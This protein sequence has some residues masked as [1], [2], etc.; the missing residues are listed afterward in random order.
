MTKETSLL[1]QYRIQKSST[2][3]TIIRHHHKMIFLLLLKITLFNPNLGT[4]EAAPIVF[5]S[6]P[7]SDS[8]SP[9]YVPKPSGR[10]TIDLLL[11]SIIT[12]MLC[13]YTSIHLNIVADSHMFSITI[14]RFRSFLKG[15]TLGQDT[16]ECNSHDAKRHYRVGFKRATVY[17]FYWVLIALFAPEFVFY[18]ALNQWNEARALRKRLREIGVKGNDVMTLEDER[19][20]LKVLKPNLTFPVE[21]SDWSNMTTTSAFFVIMGGYAYRRAYDFKIS[22][23]DLKFPYISLT[24]EGFL[25]LARKGVLQPG[26]L[27]DKAITDRSKAD[28]LAE[29]LVCAQALWMVLNVIGR[30]ASGLPSTLIELNVIVHV[31]VM[32]VVYGLWW[33]KPLAVQNPVILNPLPEYIG[34]Q[35]TK[36]LSVL[37]SSSRSRTVE[38]R[39]LCYEILTLHKDDFPLRKIG[40]IMG[41]EYLQDNRITRRETFKRTY[42]RLFGFYLRFSRDWRNHQNYR[43]STITAE[44]HHQRYSDISF[45]ERLNRDYFVAVE[46]ASKSDEEKGKQATGI[47]VTEINATRE[48]CSKGLRLC[49]GEVLLS[50]KAGFDTYAAVT[51]YR[52]PVFVPEHQMHLMETLMVAYD[53]YTPNTGKCTWGVPEASNINQKGQLSDWSKAIQESDWLPTPVLTI[54]GTILS[55]IFAGCHATAWNTHFPSFTER[56]LWTGACILIAAGSTIGS[57]K[58]SSISFIISCKWRSYSSCLFVFY[59]ILRQGYLSSWKLLFPCEVFLWVPTIALTGLK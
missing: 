13:V 44:E 25:E 29:L 33:D 50:K 53:A 45:P 48:N 21:K 57:A 28:W 9:S 14:P 42:L 22:E 5:S 56:C 27:D 3:E 30:K 51:S 47:G 40:W 16:P 39:N 1:Q 43:I 34:E 37:I 41:E 20:W 49:Q 31:V 52:R 19:R 23:S 4:V 2:L 32:V 55:L 46:I 58:L 35:Y 18:A 24:A 8:A 12:L 36:M 15:K 11:T 54:G 59:C 6:R 26:I 10:G 7:T 38:A 17:K